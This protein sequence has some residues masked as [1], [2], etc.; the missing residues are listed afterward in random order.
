[1]N[2]SFRRIPATLWAGLGFAVLL[3]VAA[4]VAPFAQSQGPSGLVVSRSVNMVSG[5]KWPTGDPYLQRQN[6]PSV[7]ASTRNPQHLL[8]G[9]NDYRTVDMPGIPSETGD[10][11]LGIFKSFDGGDRWQTN[12]LPG[13]PQ[14]TSPEG[15][16][17]PLRGFT[18]GADPVVRPGTNGLLYYAGLAFNRGE[19]QPSAVFLSRFID[20]NNTENGD[21]IKYLGTTIIDKS[22]GS[23]FIDKPWM[24]VDVPRAGAKSCRIVVSQPPPAEMK[25]GVGWGRYSGWKKNEEKRRETEREAVKKGKKPQPAP[26]KDPRLVAQTIDAG[27]IYVAYSR[28]KTVGTAVESR[29]MFSQS[30]DCGA[31]WTKPVQLSNPLDK[32]NQGANIAIDPKTGSVYVAWRQF[33]LTVNDPDSVMVARMSATNKGFEAANRVRKFNA[34]RPSDRLRK[35]IGEHQGGDADEV[36]AIQPFDQGTAEDRFRTN[37]YPTIAVDDESRAYVAWTERG[38]G[39]ARPNSMD[40]VTRQPL[41]DGDARVVISTSRNGAAWTAPQAVDAGNG[42]AAGRPGG[43]MPGHQ[44]MPSISFA[45]GKLVVV[46]YDLREDISRVFG[47]F[48]SERDAVN[49]VRI[50][51]TIDIRAAYAAK[52]DVPVFGPSQQVSSYLQGNVRGGT[53]VGPLQAN[54]PNLPLFKLGTVPFLGDY[55]DI[56]PSPAFV[57]NAKGV[58]GYNTTAQASPVFHVVW[59]D[60]RDVQKPADGDWTHYTPVGAATDPGKY[61]EAPACVPGQGGMRNQNIYSARLTWGLVA[62]SPG[63]TKPLDA[64]MPRAFVVFAQNTTTTTKTFRFSIG[65]QPVGGLASF[66]QTRTAGT[67]YPLMSLDVSV[68]AKSMVTRTVF[69]TSTDPKAQVPVDVQE[70]SAPGAN[71]ISGGLASRVILNPDISNPE[72]SNPE[73]SNPEISNPEISNTEVYNPEISNPEISNPEIS[74]P[75]ISNPEISNPEISNIVVANPEISNPEISNPEISN[76]EIS[77]PEISNPEISNL[78]L[79]NSS[80]T[81]VTWSII[82]TG[83][84]TASFNVNLFLANA[85]AKLSAGGIKTQLVVH[86]TYTTPVALGCSLKQEL[87]RVLV[88][89]VINPTFTE[90]GTSTAF[91]PANSS[92]TNTTLWLEPGGE[93]KITLRVLDPNP[94]DGITIDPVHDVT[95]VV[96]AEPKNTPDLTT[97]SVPPPSTTPPALP[98]VTLAFTAQPTNTLVN[99]AIAP[100]SVHA[101]VGANPG[102]NVQVTLAIAINPAAG[103]LSGT[104]TL[105]TDAAGNATFTGL[106]I[107]KAGIGYRLS[108]S[109]SAAGAVPDLSAPFNIGAVAPPP[110]SPYVVT[111]T[112]DSGAGSFRQALIASNTDPSAKT[113]SF[114]IPGTGPFTIAVSPANP[115]PSIVQPVVIDAT[116]QPGYDGRPMV[117]IDG[118]GTGARGLELDVTATVKGLSLTGFA[119]DAAVLVMNG[120]NGSV[121]QFNHIGTDRV[122]TTAIANGIGVKLNYASSS[123]VRDNLISG[124]V[125]SGVIVLGGSANEIRSN[126]I[127]TTVDGLG[128]LANLDSGITLFDGAP[129]TVIDSNYIAGNAHA[130]IDAQSGLAPVNGLTIV[131]NTIGLAADGVTRLPNA[132]GGVRLDATIGTVVGAVGQG[133]VISGNGTYNL[134][135]SGDLCDISSYGPGIWVLGTSVL[136]PVIKANYIG[137]DATGTIALPNLY[138][139]IALGGAATVGGSAPG[140]GNVISGNGCAAAGAGSGVSA[141]DGSGGSVIRGNTIGLSATGAASLGNGFAGLTLT[142]ANSGPVVVGGPGVGDGNVISGNAQAGVAMYPMGFAPHGITVQGNFIGT[143][144]DGSTARPNG[145]WGVY[146]SGSNDIHLIG[147]VIARNISRGVYLAPDASTVSMVSNRIF[148]N[149]GTG[150]ELSGAA[151]NSQA[152]PSLSVQGSL[153]LSGH[154]VVDTTL[155]GGAGTYTYEFFAGASCGAAEQVLNSATGGPG[156]QTFE[157]NTALPTGTWVTATV[158]DSLGNTSQLAPCAQ[159]PAPFAGTITSVTPAAQLS[160]GGGQMLWIRG[161]GLQGITAA[162][163]LFSSN[164]STE[165]PA[166]YVWTLTPT[167]AVARPL[168]VISG[169]PAAGPG[170]VRVKNPSGTATTA[171][172]PVLFSNTPGAP[173]ALDIR[174]GCG[175]GAATNNGLPGTSISVHAEG[176]DTSGA[177]IIW[178]GPGGTVTQGVLTTTGGINSSVAECT[179]VPALAPGAYTVQVM[180]SSAWFSTDS[181]PSNALSFTITSS[182]TITSVTPVNGA[183]GEG[184]I[185]VRG[186]NLPAGIG[187]SVAEVTTGVTTQNGFV[188]PSPTTP[189]AVYV[190][191]PFG[192]PLGAG[193][194][195]IRNLA[196]TIVSNAFPITLTATPGVPVI[197]AIREPFGTIVAAPVVAGTQ[198]LVGADGIDT[199]GAVVR[200][201]QGARTW[202]VTGGAASNNIIGTTLQVNMPGDAMTGPIDVSIRQGASAFS[203][204]VTISVSN[205]GFF[206]TAGGFGGNAFGPVTCNPGSVLTALTGEAGSYMGQ[207]TM[208]CAPVGPGPSLGTAVASAVIGIPGVGPVGFGAALT[209]PAGSMIT[210]IHGTAGNVLWG[211]VVDGLAVDCKDVATAAP[212]SSGVVGG[213]VTTPF[214]FQCPTGDEGI[215]FAGGFGGVLDRI[216]IVCANRA[217]PTP[218]PA[219]SPTGTSVDDELMPVMSLEDVQAAWFDPRRKLR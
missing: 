165:T 125:F 135:T 4:N 217:A 30:D 123:I 5:N 140:E 50:R 196:G 203:S 26:N 194:I 133:N 105:L 55:I 209:C 48:I 172:Y 75:E 73:I 72:I 89:N 169:G 208:W 162:D 195:R 38:Y 51:H 23:D 98:N 207:F 147:N 45:A 36:A 161:T 100:I 198:I 163:V 57:Q 151:N 10:A 116:T 184:F 9:A 106:S 79:L 181:A 216:G 62:G 164:G 128:A 54:A 68:P 118:T 192:Q 31:T 189:S 139:G 83:N 204:P 215:G 95:P 201:T 144:A 117:R 104:T 29:I 109:A 170:Y 153:S 155:V 107:E 3:V 84:T 146:V 28:I 127:G 218:L 16:A 136:P 150:I 67:A 183:P 110:P 47:P 42:E 6:E 25:A 12:L 121:I 171:N 120:V 53:Q 176:V 129:G 71:L 182:A 78:N 87:H 33:G 138:E 86:K 39:R 65:S 64:T 213:G 143:A 1:M 113:I 27:R 82:N 32:V 177:S 99:A 96:T 158:T 81:D 157:L 179:T 159:V 193:T 74:N 76:P 152:A 58:W 180:T 59:T 24:A 97:P 2:A 19:N 212:Y 211:V 52:G 187:D 63:N 178:T 166:Q 66:T 185:A 108:A 101:Q 142:P 134:A 85:A 131:R 44:L 188:F 132:T 22:N 126:K 175:V 114:A 219:P 46:Y 20:N 206:G 49:N 168:H 91:D 94:T 154:T 17:S 160:A 35:M 92:V 90:P 119:A 115:L 202:D 199:T 43:D 37:A 93:G 200:F 186:V 148:L 56:A 197:T 112:N 145:I 77:N 88:A 156:G 41:A 21:P 13:Y 214:S 205:P 167:L 174:S 7:A 149:G 14:D 15:L 70:V 11:W 111:N 173:V 102:A 210:G 190:R 137:T 124:N 130:G 60:N 61:A 103:H 8:A 80:I 18:A 40:P 122:G 191:L 141:V 34:R 69:A